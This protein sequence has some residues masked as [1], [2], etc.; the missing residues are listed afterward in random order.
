ME[1]ARKITIEVRR[2]LLEKAQRATGSG[3]TQTVRAGLELVAHRRPT[4]VYVNSGA[5]FALPHISR[6]QG[7]PVIAVGGWVAPREPFGV[8]NR[9]R[10]GWHLECCVLIVERS[11]AGSP[12]GIIETAVGVQCYWQQHARERAP[13]AQLGC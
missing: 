9:A 1:T 3:I 11:Q 10:V 5:R 4:P 7:R 8:I 2:E 6:T 13:C 12:S